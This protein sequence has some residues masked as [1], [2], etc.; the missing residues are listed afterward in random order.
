MFPEGLIQIAVLAHYISTLNGSETCDSESVGRWTPAVILTLDST[1]CSWRP[2]INSLWGIDP[3]C[4]VICTVSAP[5]RAIKSLASGRKIALVSQERI[6]FK[7][8]LP[9]LL[10]HDVL[11]AVSQYSRPRYVSAYL[12]IVSD[13]RC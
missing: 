11:P 10:L 4:F 7:I 8:P 6:K 13:V 2:L 1:A 3:A 12:E 9:L 5:L